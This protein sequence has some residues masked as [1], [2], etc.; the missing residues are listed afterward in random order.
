MQNTSG[1]FSPLSC[2][3]GKGILEHRR[4]WA[5]SCVF[6]V[7][8]L[9]G[10]ILKKKLRAIKEKHIHISGFFT[11]RWVAP[12]LDPSINV[13]SRQ[14]SFLA[15]GVYEWQ[16]FPEEAGRAIWSQWSLCRANQPGYLTAYALLWPT[17]AGGWGL[18]HSPWTPP[19]WKLLITAPHSFRHFLNRK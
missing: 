8:C 10:W 6:T 9:C 5:I 18:H 3:K 1:V 4:V 19:P 13:L 7:S 16:Q 15:D 2:S 17:P 12:R 14:T 11:S